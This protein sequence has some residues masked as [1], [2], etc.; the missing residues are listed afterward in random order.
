MLDRHE[1]TVVKRSEQTGV[2]PTLSRTVKEIVSV[3]RKLDF[4]I[5]PPD[6]SQNTRDSCLSLIICVVLGREGG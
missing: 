6:K 5:T 1:F 2:V 3:Q 4:L